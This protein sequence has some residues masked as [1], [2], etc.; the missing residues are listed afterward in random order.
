MSTNQSFLEVL[1]DELLRGWG[2]VVLLLNVSLQL[3]LKLHMA[4]LLLLFGVLFFL[5]VDCG[6]VRCGCCVQAL[7]TL[8]QCHKHRLFVV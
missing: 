7:I 2:D 1:I 3:H 6:L 5:S 4:A 8:F